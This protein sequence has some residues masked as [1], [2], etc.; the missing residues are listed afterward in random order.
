MNRWYWSATLLALLIVQV[1]CTQTPPPPPDTRAADEK[2]IRDM[3]SQVAKDFAAKDLDKIVSEYAEDAAFLMANQPLLTGR[4]AI[5]AAMQKVLADPA[6]A[7]DLTTTKVEVAKSAE[8][9]YSQGSYTYNFTDPRTKKAVGEK[10]KYV[11]V[12]K[13]QADGSWKIV[14]DTAIPDGP[15]TPAKG[16]P[17]ARSRT[18]GRAKKA[19]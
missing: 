17:S 18:K 16:N 1:A 11:E 13:K 15:P 7:L 19:K 5:R 14:E 12:Y 4:D 8:L 3:E 2:A 6:I 9:A 10:G